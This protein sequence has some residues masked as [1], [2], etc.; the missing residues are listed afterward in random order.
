MHKYGNVLFEE[1]QQFKAGWFW[2]LLFAASIISFSFLYFY[3][4]DELYRNI[5][6]DKDSL[7]LSGIIC[8]ISFLILYFVFLNMRLELRIFS[9]GLS[10]K[11]PPFKRKFKYI[12]NEDIRKYVVRDYR[13]IREFGGWGYRLGF[14]GKFAYSIKGKK[15]LQLYLKDG[16][17]IL[18]GTQRSEAISIAMQKM[19]EE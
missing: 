12:S 11:F 5:N 3:G 15:G 10:F 2:L 18:L 16:S 13:P 1:S 19:M 4:N 14:G 6:A 17:I 9:K 8:S 7:L